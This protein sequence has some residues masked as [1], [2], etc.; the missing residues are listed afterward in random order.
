MR[1]VE[2]LLTY[3]DERRHLGRISRWG[4]H[5]STGFSMS[6]DQES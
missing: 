6:Q 4:P 1:I 5:D 3:H 2:I